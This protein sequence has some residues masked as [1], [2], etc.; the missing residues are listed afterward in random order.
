M[1][2]MLAAFNDVASS[3]AETLIAPGGSS[4]SYVESS[5]EGS[6]S[7]R[8]ASV[9][10]TLDDA[11]SPIEGKE[12]VEEEEHT[13]VATEEKTSGGTGWTDGGSASSS[14]FE[15]GADGKPVSQL[16][17]S[18]TATKAIRRKRE[19]TEDDDEEDEENKV[20]RRQQTPWKK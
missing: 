17:I 8:M 11:D 5:V 19:E 12:D 3:N 1:N 20:K 6:E 7:A 4:S 14:V 2:A 13:L 16:E 18:K 15:E 9:L 10:R